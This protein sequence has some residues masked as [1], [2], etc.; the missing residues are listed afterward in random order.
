MIIEKVL[1]N[2]VVITLDKDNHEMVVMG[3][4][5]AFGKKKGGMISEEKIEKI[6]K[7]NKEENNSKFESLLKNIPIDYFDITEKI[8]E[9]SK[10][11]GLVLQKSILFT[12][13]DHIHNS[14]ERF[15][16]NQSIANG[17]LI[18][19]KR[20]YPREFEIGKYGLVLIKEKLGTDLPED[21]AAFISLHIIASQISGDINDICKITEF[22][23]EICN[24]TE[25]F[26]NITLDDST[27]D[28]YR[29]V[30][31]IKF[32]GQRLFA[33]KRLSD[34]EGIWDIIGG[35]NTVTASECTEEISRHILSKYNYSLHRDE[36]L[37]L[38]I[39]L[40]KITKAYENQ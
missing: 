27:Y 18:E 28:Y 23:Q 35:M 11:M 13:T 30:T 37:Y 31:H 6:F 29:F 34:I 22:V 15:Q 12:L 36:K 20:I 3:S 25:A 17:L 4:G 40:M 14:V 1:N 21:E 38:V 16:N 10:E 32:L 2:N 19:I 26:Y 33:D 7:L 39:H 24:I 9:K 8:I 5:I